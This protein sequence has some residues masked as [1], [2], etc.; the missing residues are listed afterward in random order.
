M[1]PPKGMVK[2]RKQKRDHSECH[3]M[4][5]TPNFENR[6]SQRSSDPGGSD[7]DTAY[8]FNDNWGS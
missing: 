2:K 3:S 1:G 5:T 4:P 7:S 8:G 6:G